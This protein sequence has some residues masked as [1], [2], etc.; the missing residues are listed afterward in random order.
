MLI[1]DKYVKVGTMVIVVV[2]IMRQKKIKKFCAP[3][4]QIMLTVIRNSADS[5]VF[6]ADLSTLKLPVVLF[7]AGNSA[8][9]ELQ[10]SD[11][12]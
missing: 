4:L 9:A 1:T 6:E 10:N 2:R 8:I 11:I 5:L 3:N 7:S 12:P